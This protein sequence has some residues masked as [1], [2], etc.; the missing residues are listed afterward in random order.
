[1][2]NG[3]LYVLAALFPRKQPTAIRYEA[4]GSSV[5]INALAKRKNSAL[6]RN[7]SLAV[8]TVLIQYRLN[9]DFHEVIYS[10]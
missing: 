3:Q 7:Q 5:D 2:A 8:Q 10:F 1:V 9:S 4:S 6:V